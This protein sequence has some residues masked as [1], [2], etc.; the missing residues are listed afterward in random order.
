MQQL[1]ELDKNA[2]HQQAVGRSCGCACGSGS[3]VRRKSG[4][5]RFSRGGLVAEA[6]A[7]LLVNKSFERIFTHNPSSLDR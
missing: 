7:A 4:R 2:P 5:G 6:A 1:P 3:G